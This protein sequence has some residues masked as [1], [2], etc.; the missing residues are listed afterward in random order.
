MFRV[1]IAGG[2]DFQDYELL[3]RTMD[4]LL[5]NVHGQIVVVC[6]LAP[7]AD[8]LGDQY[9]KAKG[10]EVHYFPADWAKYGRAAGPIRNEQMAQN[11]DALVAFWNGISKGTKS[12]IELAQRYGLKIR[13]KRI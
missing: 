11:A 12:M 6:G 7:G 8:S 5:S 9:A 4:H 1:I 3:A 2:R 10:Y 13:I